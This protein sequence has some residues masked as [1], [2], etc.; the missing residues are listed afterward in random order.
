MPVKKSA[1]GASFAE[2]FQ[3][4]Q[5]GR[6]GRHDQRERDDGFNQRF[7]GPIAARQQPCRGQPE[8]QYDQGAE[9]RNPRRERKQLPL[10][11]GHEQPRASVKHDKSIFLKNVRGGFRVEIARKFF[12]GFNLLRVLHHRQWIGNFRAA[13]RRNFIGDLHFFRNGGISFEHDAGLNIA[14]FHGRERGAHVVD[15]NN[16]GFDGCPKIFLLKKCLRVNSRRHG[17]RIRQRN[18]PHIGSG[19]VGGRR[20][21]ELAVGRGHD[22]ERVGKAALASFL[23]NKSL[24]RERV[25]FSFIGGEENVRRRALLDLPFEQAGRAEIEED[26]VVVLFLVSRGGFLQYIR[27]ACSGKNCYVRG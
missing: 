27:Q 16:L 15:G 11:G 1:H 9:R 26:F 21:L 24:G 4:N 2:N 17:F 19:Q 5:A 14:G 22:D 25:H 7:S 23:Q 20:D 13:R 12:G 8:R 18:P 10:F 3:Q 6:H